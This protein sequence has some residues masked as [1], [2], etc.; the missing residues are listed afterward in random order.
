MVR[1]QF[2]FWTVLLVLPD[3]L[4]LSIGPRIPTRNHLALFSRPCREEEIEFAPAF[5]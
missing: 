1:A 3:L 5:G 4:V 2:A